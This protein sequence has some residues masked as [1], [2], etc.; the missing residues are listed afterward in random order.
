MAIVTK[1][2]GPIS[3]YAIA[4]E[5]GYTGTKEQFAQEI[6]NAAAN[7]QAAAASATA[8]D[9]YAT[10]AAT[11]ASN[12]MSTTPA[13][14]NSMM[15]SIAAEY[16]A[17]A[18]YAV[19]DYCRYNSEVYCCVTPI[20]AAEAFDS[21]KWTKV[22]IGGQLSQIS[23]EIR[24]DETHF[25]KCESGTFADA[26]GK[27]KT[28]NNARIR[29]ANPVLVG[30]F[31][32][33]TIPTGFDAWIFRLD[34][35]LSL[36]SAVGGWLSGDVNFSTIATA[37]TKYI[38]FAIRKSDATSSDIS[39][40]IDA[41][42]AGLILKKEQYMID[43]GNIQYEL[44][45]IAYAPSTQNLMNP[46]TIT[47][48][49][50]LNSSGSPVASASRGLSDFI[51][52]YGHSGE[53]VYNTYGAGQSADDRTFFPVHSYCF[54]GADK[55]TV[56]ECKINYNGNNFAVPENAYWLRIGADRTHMK[57]RMMTY[58]GTGKI[59]YEPF[60]YALKLDN[61]IKTI[62]P[63]KIWGV[64]G[65]P[66][67]VY[68]Y[69]ILQLNSIEN[70]SFVVSP[71]SSAVR[72][73]GDRIWFSCTEA[74]SYDL[75]VTVKNVNDS[76]ALEF[77]LSV[78]IVSATLPSIKA[79]FIGD[80]FVDSGYIQS[81]LI[82]KM[83]ANLT[84][85][86]T[87][88][89]T[90]IPDLANVN[91]S[92]LD[93][94]RYG[95]RL[96]Q[97][98]NNESV[99]GVPNAFYDGTSFNFSYYMTQH[100]TF[101]DTTDVFI[102]SGANDAGWGVYNYML[103]MGRIVESIKAYSESIRIHLLIPITVCTTGYGYGSRSYSS[104]E[105]H[106]NSTIA[107]AQALIEQYKNDSSVILTPIHIDIDRVHDFP[108]TQIAASDHN[109]ELITVYNDNVHPSRYGYYGIASSIFGDIVANCQ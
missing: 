66:F 4:K 98:W 64:V 6:G 71:V 82:G 68:F 84:L 8:A 87:R 106:R 30:E 29:N 48:G 20:S 18:T 23:E 108:T 56:I 75:T 50:T 11:S 45:C 104:G 31:K 41:V 59:A 9:G 102:L 19:G 21:T 15:A 53:Y 5:E 17:T 46:F 37:D 2:I 79:I 62:I 10:S 55:T 67:S 107:L 96:S 58:Y 43:N 26:D 103:Y 105:Q 34:Y 83:G 35:N 89:F 40:Y 73:Y 44:D 90:D 13:G 33:L 36:I 88:S 97:Y 94:G 60:E 3:A 47:D 100:P 76:T 72:N 12:A 24:Q 57:D 32:T 70:Y 25:I 38:N 63:P 42:A 16:D 101:S 1:K 49:T 80:S 91:H 27:T 86:G 81:Q 77:N 22:T 14:Y 99:S 93:E 54:Y 51:D 39:S 52:V 65:N 78:E 95:W 109:P 69:N 61:E 7:A 85:Y 74:T 92:G 28:T